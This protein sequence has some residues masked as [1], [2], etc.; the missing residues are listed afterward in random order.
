MADE[1]GEMQYMAPGKVSGLNITAMEQCMRDREEQLPEFIGRIFVFIC[2]S[3]FIIIAFVL[4]K[5]LIKCFNGDLI[6]FLIF[7]LVPN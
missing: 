2:L 5:S 3:Y 6:M 1:L 4:F 7:I